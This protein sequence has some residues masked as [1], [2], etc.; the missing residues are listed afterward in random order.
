MKRPVVLIS[1]ILLAGALL[2][3]ARA[4]TTPQL[5][6]IAVGNVPAEMIDSLVSHFQTKCDV[7]IK[8]L[9]P[10]WPDRQTFDRERSQAVADRLIE[11]VWSQHQTVAEDSR[12]RIIGI[13]PTDMFME[14]KRD[15][16]SFAFS[17]RSGDGRIAVISYARLNPRNLGRAPNDMVLSNRLRKM[18]AKNIGLMHFGLPASDNPRSVLFRNILGVDDLDRMTEE[19]DPKRVED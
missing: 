14:A 12:S 3:A 17:L 18:V 7:S 9:P 11:A 10:V 8:T 16:W 2:V 19:F 1:A 6:F 4:A 15:Q 5:Y 13:T